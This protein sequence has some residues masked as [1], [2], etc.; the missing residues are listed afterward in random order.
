ML[1]LHHSPLACSLAIRFALA[2]SGLPHEIA[3]VQ[4]PLGENKTD[5]YLKINPRGKVPALEAD[6]GVLTEGSAILSYI[7]DLAPEKSLLPNVGTFARAQ[8]QA[9]L[10]FFSSTLHSAFGALFNPIDGCEGDAAKQAYIARIASAFGEVD[11]HLKNRETI[12]DTF[13]V[14][15]LYLAVFALWRMSPLL[16]GKLPAFPEIDRHM[17]SVL[18]RPAL[19]GILEEELRLKAEAEE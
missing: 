17:Q 1:R 5:A 3:I 9:W 10:S 4:I 11:D 8:A 13:S 6:A 7:A 2:E 16:A 12:L 18:G 19:N 14:C 15:D